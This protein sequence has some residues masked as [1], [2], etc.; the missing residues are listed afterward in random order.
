MVS[1]RHRR[2]EVKG[3]VH[4]L[5]FQT[6]NPLF[7]REELF[8]QIFDNGLALNEAIDGSLVVFAEIWFMKVV[9]FAD[10]DCIAGFWAESAYDFL[11]INSITLNCR[12]I[13]SGHLRAEIN[14]GERVYCRFIN[15]SAARNLNNG[16]PLNH[17]RKIIWYYG[18]VVVVLPLTQL[19]KKKRASQF[20]LES[21]WPAAKLLLWWRTDT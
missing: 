4:Y 21:E 2:R 18:M 17:S 12:G 5:V 19:M 3:H 10:A 8:L 15:D 7:F 20:V 13:W 16:Q 9:K 6:Y 14:C 1:V 11:Y